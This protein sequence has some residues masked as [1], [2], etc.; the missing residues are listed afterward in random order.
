[1]EHRK[2]HHGRGSLGATR[3]VIFLTG[4]RERKGSL[5]NL[6]DKEGLGMKT[7]K[8]YLDLSFPKRS[9]LR[10]F[11]PLEKKRE[12]CLR[13]WGLSLHDGSKGN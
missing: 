2:D 13:N 10:I 5:C 8:I 11:E 3:G 6:Q 4:K 7:A 12:A 1:M 9:L